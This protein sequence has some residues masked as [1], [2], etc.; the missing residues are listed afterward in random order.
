[1]PIVLF[2]DS[3]LIGICITTSMYIIKPLVVYTFWV[4][5]ESM[6]VTGWPIFVYRGVRIRN[7]GHTERLS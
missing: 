5:C 3:P 1:M 2:K 6:V 7:Y 4:L